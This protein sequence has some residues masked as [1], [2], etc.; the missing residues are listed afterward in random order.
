MAAS[1]TS[2][3]APHDTT[4]LPRSPAGSNEGKT[5]Y[6]EVEEIM[7]DRLIA[8]YRELEPD[9]D[10]PSQDDPETRRFARA[11]IAAALGLDPPPGT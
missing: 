1:M 6:T 5:P 8:K 10:V 9:D 4:A 7:V 2:P 3:P 11:L